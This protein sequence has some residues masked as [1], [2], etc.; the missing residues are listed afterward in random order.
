MTIQIISQ[1]KK[2]LIQDC[3]SGVNTQRISEET[4]DEPGLF[5]DG[6][7]VLINENGKISEIGKQILKTEKHTDYNIG[8]EYHTSF[9]QVI[10]SRT[11]DSNGKKLTQKGSTKSQPTET[12]LKKFFKDAKEQGIKL[13]N[14][15]ISLRQIFGNS[16]K[17]TLSQSR[18]KVSLRL[19][20]EM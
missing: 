6:I 20:K 7:Y 4:I 17:S 14:L 5:P 13:P 2:T 16:L 9:S 10:A 12:E 18:Q 1:G 3:T 8:S 19:G 11:F 15:S